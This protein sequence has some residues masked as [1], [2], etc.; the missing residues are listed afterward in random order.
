MEALVI[1]LV[2]FLLLLTIFILGIVV[3]IYLR[4][5][6][7]KYLAP[8]DKYDKAWDEFYKKIPPRP[9]LKFS[10]S[11]SANRF[12][13]FFF[14]YSLAPAFVVFLVSDHKTGFLDLLAFLLM[15]IPLSLFF[16]PFFP[17]GLIELITQYSFIRY[18]HFFIGHLIYITICLLGVFAKNRRVFNFIYLIFLMFLIANIIGCASMIKD[19]DL[20]AIN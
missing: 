13:I 15:S 6:Q 5:E 1:N 16:L 9:Y 4:Q 18:D 17:M 19:I 10:Y 14:T 11:L 7:K 2:L 8:K 20:S 12:L 3:Y